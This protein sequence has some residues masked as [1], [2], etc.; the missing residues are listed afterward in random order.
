MRLTTEEAAAGIIAV[1]ET[2]LRQAVETITIERGRDP[3]SMTLVAAGGAG[4]LHGSPVGRA[5]GCRWLVVPAQAGVF[6]ATGMLEADLRRD[7]SRSI[8]GDLEELAGGGLSA[9][10]DRE[11]EM[12][13]DLV[14]EEWPAEVEPVTTSHVELRYPGQLWSVRVP[15]GDVA[16]AAGI[17]TRFE[18]RYRALYGHIQPGGVLEVTGIGVV[19]TGRLDGGDG[20]Q[21]EPMPRAA[22]SPSSQR[23]CWLG[24]GLGWAEVAV[25]RGRDLEPGHRVDGP[26]L[27]DGETTTVLGLP[28]DRLSVAADG[29]LEV[30]LT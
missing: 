18:D 6:C 13:R 25:Y 19:A 22:P 28:G 2:H 29:D 7:R 30:A 15:L 10:V 5:L 8:L 27:I 12:V 24:E 20:P 11:V 14:A 1:L 26:Y 16:D 17:R 4:G 21:P 3:T 23:R 9:A